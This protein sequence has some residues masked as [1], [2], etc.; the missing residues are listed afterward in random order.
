MIAFLKR[1]WSAAPV[2]T[3]ILALALGAVGVFGVRSV[4][5]AVYF[6]NPAHRMQP[7]APWMTPG[8]IA[9]AWHIPRD[10]VLAALD[11]PM[12]PPEGPMSLEELAA[13]RG[14]PLAQVMA[15]AEALVAPY[16]EAPDGTPAPP[17]PPAEPRP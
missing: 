9:R 15:E 5:H 10:E 4:V 13:Y 1:L 2:A 11:A 12:P 16:R 3:L 8:F 6:A 14:V 7:V 17:P